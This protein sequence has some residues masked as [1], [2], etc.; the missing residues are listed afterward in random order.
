MNK[1]KMMLSVIIPIWKR[2]VQLELILTK[3]NEQAE[4]LSTTL[5]IVLCDSHSGNE[6]DVI[7]EKGINNL[8]SL[9]VIHTHTKNV[10]AAKRNHGVS[11]STGDYLI[12]LDDDCIPDTSFLQSV[13]EI[14]QDMNIDTVYCGEVRFERELVNSSNYYRYRDSKHPEY[15][16]SAPVFFNEWT[17]VAMNCLIA[18][19]TFNRYNVFYN[20]NFLGYGC[21]DHEFASHLKKMGLKIKFSKQKIYHHEYDGDILTYA[22]KIRATARDGMLVLLKT[23]P[24][25]INTNPKLRMIERF[26][27]KDDIRS[28]YVINVFFN[29]YISGAVANFLLKYDGN[30]NRYFPLLYRY[31]LICAYIKGVCERGRIDRNK[32]HQNW[33]V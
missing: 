9:S 11:V 15:N 22:N 23:T 5:E 25:I 3:L 18:R 30:S 20:E 14:I 2:H 31:V 13:F 12:F 28:K 33:Y 8:Q 6:I 1:D 32:L 26:F 24:D 17:F 29:K 4:A 19:E 7:V 10:L 27:S 16:E 21:E